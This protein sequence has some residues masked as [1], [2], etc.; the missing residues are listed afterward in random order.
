[1]FLCLMIG[2][3][4][5]IVFF[6]LPKDVN[7]YTGLIIQNESKKCCRRKLNISNTIKTYS[8][9]GHFRQSSGLKVEDT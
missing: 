1:M 5:T 2:E 7:H 9:D 6:F 4:F 3:S 8:V